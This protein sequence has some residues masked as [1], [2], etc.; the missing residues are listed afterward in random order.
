METLQRQHKTE[1]QQLT[2]HFSQI[3]EYKKGYCPFLTFQVTDQRKPRR[4]K[5]YLKVNW[6]SELYRF[7]VWNVSNIQVQRDHSRKEEILTVQNKREET[8][9]KEEIRKKSILAAAGTVQYF[10]SLNDAG[11]Q[12]CY[13]ITRFLSSSVNVLCLISPHHSTLLQ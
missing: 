7:R 10:P 13:N 3:K 5:L 4:R 9:D 8:S 11:S 1:A 2:S 12:T 6:H